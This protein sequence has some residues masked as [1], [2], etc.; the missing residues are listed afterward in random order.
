MNEEFDKIMREKLTQVNTPP[1]KNGWDNISSEISLPRN[2]IIR[3]GSAILVMG[4]L[5]SSMIIY[6]PREV[7]QLTYSVDVTI[8]HPQ[9]LEVLKFGEANSNATSISSKTLVFENQLS[10]RVNTTKPISE[11]SGHQ[12]NNTEAVQDQNSQTA[13]NVMPKKAQK[14]MPGFKGDQADEKSESTAVFRILD[15]S[16][17]ID[18]KEFD[19]KTYTHKVSMQKVRL[20]DSSVLEKSMEPIKPERRQWIQGIYLEGNSFLN[21]NRVK[22][23]KNDE[24]LITNLRN[25]KFNERLGYSISLGV[26]KDLSKRIFVYAGLNFQTYI[27]KVSFDYVERAA[28]SLNVTQISNN[29]FEVVPVDVERTDILEQRINSIGLETG[30]RYVM[31]AGKF[32][33]VI[34]VGLLGNTQFNQKRTEYIKPRQFF[35]RFGYGAYYETE[36]PWVFFAQP[37]ISYSLLKEDGSGGLFH[38]QPFSLGLAV[39]VKYN[40]K[41]R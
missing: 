4:V 2:L 18:S 39:G 32:K 19:G 29:S 20:V 31:Q 1:P 35:V 37:S 7:K 12:P 27:S 9:Q 5:L 25:N 3:L 23:N 21:Y 13:G 22:P 41:G 10:T 34:N 24:V 17:F 33:N 30:L 26:H 38:V 14:Q 28:D 40:F 16:V 15:K 36:S 6:G 8:D 11:I